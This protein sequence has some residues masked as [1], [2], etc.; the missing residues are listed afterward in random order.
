MSFNAQGWRPVTLGAVC[1]KIGSG[2]TPRGGQDSYTPTGVALIRSQNVLDLR[3]TEEGLARIPDEAADALR[4]VTVETGDVLLNITGQSVARCCMVPETVLPARV[5]Q[6]VAIVRPDTEK[7]DSRFLQYALIA[8]KPRLLALAGAGA[9][10]EALT[11]AM[12]S[13]FEIELPPIEEQRRISTVLGSLDAKIASNHLLAGTLREIATAFFKARFI[14]FVG[15]N[16]L[17]ETEIGKIPDEWRIVTF[18]E[19]IAVNPPVEAVTRETM[20]PFIGMADV[21]AWGVRPDRIEE[22]KYSG[23]ARFEPGDTLMARITGCIEHGKGVFVDFFDQPAAG[24]T[25]FLVF[26]AKPPL[27]PEMVFFFSRTARIRDHAIANMSGSSGRQRVQKAAFD[28]IAIAIP[29]NAACIE[30]EAVLFRRVFERTR[31]LWR[32]NQVLVG[33]RDLLLP[34]LMSGR[35]RIDGTK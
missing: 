31:A 23:G 34:K 22:R 27:T 14:D 17:Q 25:E 6:H 15:R 19:A 28:H 26:R 3:F 30:E 8:N 20:T 29:Q 5:N 4:H 18:S 33:I 24:S 32:E 13:G 16:D 11:K 35:L 21:P 2:A 12:I 10:R 9:T 7:L 1:R